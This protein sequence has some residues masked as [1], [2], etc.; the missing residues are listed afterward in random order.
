LDVL[1][2]SF[3]RVINSLRISIT[4][5]CN[6]RCLYCMPSNGVKLTPKENILTFEEV[7]RIVRVGARLGINKVK[8]TGGEPLVR[9]GMV[10]LVRKISETDGI[11]DLS[12]TTNGMFLEEL[13]SGLFHAG[14]RRVNVSLDS[15]DAERFA[16][17]TRGGKLSKV[18]A[19]ID[20]TLELG[21]KVKINVVALR[22]FND[23]EILDFVDFARDRSVQIR[24]IEFMPLCGNSWNRSLFILLSEVK[25]LIANHFELVPIESNGT[26]KMYETNQGVRIGFIPT[27]SDPFCSTCSRLRLTAWGSLR[28]CLFSSREIHILPMLRRYAPDE[29][30]MEA[31]KRAVCFKPE[32]NPCLA[33]EE[34]F[35]NILVRNIGG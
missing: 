18:L 1:Q 20:K 16:Q 23:S 10:D 28:P 24:F 25:D 2:D 14:L 17:L 3:G 15:L 30:I 35:E 4:D 29:R 32:F 34:R 33:G 26:A 7:L 12:L 31:F 19:G 6:L 11:E 13:V 27:L 8:L 21:V 9:Q 22:G 5:R